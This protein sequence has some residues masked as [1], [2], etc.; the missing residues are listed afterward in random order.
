MPGY[1]QIFTSSAIDRD[2]IQNRFPNKVIT[3]LPNV[4]P[5]TKSAKNHRVN[6][7]F[8]MLFVGTMGY[9]PNA[10]AVR[11][12]A[13]HI[14]PVLR[15]KSR[16]P[17]H[18][19]VVGAVPDQTW[20]RRFANHPEINFAGWVEDLELEYDEADIVVTPIRGGG[21]TRIKILEAFAYG[22]PVVSTVK[23][24]EGLDIENGVHL[25]MEDDPRRFASACLQLMNDQEMA[26][27]LSRQALDL[28]KTQYGPQA[29]YSAWTGQ[30]LGLV[31]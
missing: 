18:L 25:L 13:E 28:V 29:V 1:D 17:W 19:R 3:A 11:F 9:Y 4:V 15:E 12:F 23:G 24:A 20:I 8:T 16:R 10:D 14:A 30:S 22:I 27:A 2:I 26:D 7:V 21:G 5:I 31:T 6:R